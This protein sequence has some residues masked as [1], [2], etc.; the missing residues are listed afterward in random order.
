[1]PLKLCSW[2]HPFESRYAT[3]T[4]QW[5][6]AH[7]HSSKYKHTIKTPSNIILFWVLH[8]N[9]CPILRRD[10]FSLLTLF[11]Y[12]A[13]LLIFDID[14]HTHTH[15]YSITE[16]AVNTL[17][18]WKCVLLTVTFNWND[19]SKSRRWKKFDFFYVFLSFARLKIKI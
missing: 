9:L 11:G 3:N 18:R 2:R 8:S 7:L 10:I 15:K 5:Q 13:L 19:A 6:Q 4:N 14:T 17:L 1:M 16:F 12:G